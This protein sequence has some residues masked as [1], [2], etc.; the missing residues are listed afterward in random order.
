MDIVRRGLC[1]KPLELHLTCRRFSL[2][3]MQY[4]ELDMVTWCVMVAESFQLRFYRMTPFLFFL[5]DIL[6]QGFHSPDAAMPRFLRLL[7]VRRT[8]ASGAA[9]LHGAVASGLGPFPR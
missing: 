2:L 8:A 9:R 5:G 4:A 7:H 6:A 1:S 3:L